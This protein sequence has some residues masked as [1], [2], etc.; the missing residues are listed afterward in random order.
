MVT[1]FALIII[2]I[3]VGC[4]YYKKRKENAPQYEVK[5]DLI[6]HSRANPVRDFERSRAEFP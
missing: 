3:I 1:I 5:G 4:C 6:M 2:A